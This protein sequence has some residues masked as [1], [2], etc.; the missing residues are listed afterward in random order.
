MYEVYWMHISKFIQNTKENE[1]R[2][3]HVL[4]IKA[5]TQVLAA[6]LPANQ[7]TWF[8]PEKHFRY[9]HIQLYICQHTML[10]LEIY[11]KKL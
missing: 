11:K 6:Y 8:A 1:T 7:M 10:V 3:F 2:E 5:I 4:Y 9:M